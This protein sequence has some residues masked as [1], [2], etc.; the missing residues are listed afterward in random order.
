MDKLELFNAQKFVYFSMWIEAKKNKENN[1]IVKIPHFPKGYKD[2]TQSTI[3]NKNHSIIAI[4][5]GKIS[6]IFVI[7]IDD[8]KNETAKKL[9][10]ICFEYC[11]WKVSTRKGYHYYF[12]YDQRLNNYE[13]QSKASNINNQ[14]GF[15][16]RG[17]GGI[18]FYGKYNLDSEIYKY[19]LLEENPQ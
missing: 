7:D 5:T 8:L 13:K 14:L 10:D 18:I 15:D 4:R 2:M 19:T 17:N 3:F 1:K 6:N 16:T 12:K 11:K 9:N